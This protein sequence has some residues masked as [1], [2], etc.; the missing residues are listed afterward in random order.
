MGR[1][2]QTI[3][4]DTDRGRNV[5]DKA[6]TIFNVLTMFTPL[7]ELSR[8]KHLLNIQNDIS[9]IRQ[10]GTGISDLARGKLGTGLRTLAMGAAVGIAGVS[11]SRFETEAK[12]IS[13]RNAFTRSGIK[14]HN[15]GSISSLQSKLNVASENE[16]N[17]RVQAKTIQ[18]NIDFYTND[19]T[20]Q[21][22]VE[23]KN[24]G[25][26][27]NELERI[28]EKTPNPFRDRGFLDRLLRTPKEAEDE[29]ANEVMPFLEKKS[30]LNQDYVESEQRTAWYEKEQTKFATTIGP[31][32]QQIADYERQA[33]KS[34]DAIENLQNKLATQKSSF[35]IYNKAQNTMNQEWEEV[36][37]VVSGKGDSFWDYYSRKIGD[38]GENIE[39]KGLQRTF[40]EGGYIY[41][42]MR[43]SASGITVYSNNLNTN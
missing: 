18:D 35:Q 20:T 8:V 12:G 6:S 24:R 10:I 28:R 31:K 4:G 41:P 7:G 11:A 38:V 14:E 27:E 23:E 22:Q 16:E 2:Y 15:F 30:K 34:R 1:I 3:K 37:S 36:Y 40:I 42:L 21:L 9:A 43:G 33:A 17:F 26:L 39:K 19:Y 5:W 25:D 29:R 32:Q 13:F